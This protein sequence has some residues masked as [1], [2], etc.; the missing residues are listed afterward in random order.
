M[1]RIIPA[2]AALA[3]L[4]VGSGQARAG[5]LPVVNSGFEDPGGYYT[6]LVGWTTSNF[7][8]Y[9]VGGYS[10]P[11]LN[12]QLIPPPGIDIGNN[13]GFT[14][15]PGSAS[16]VIAGYTIQAN[17]TYTLDLL[18]GG[19]LDSSGFGFGGSLIELYDA[20]TSQVLASYELDRGTGVSPLNGVFEWQTTGF[21]TGQAGG[22]INDQL[23]ILLMGLGQSAG[24]DTQ[25]WFDNVSLTA[26]SVPEP[27]TLA[28]SCIMLGT[29]VVGWA[30]KQLK[31]TVAAE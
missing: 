30:C 23:G 11:D 3:L 20:T 16:Q 8:G 21:S 19:R 28:M 6:D 15:G 31:R 5:N 29:F 9:P 27:S 18:V 22:S 24:E 12:G 2:L 1:R 14:Q 26:S 25:T 10:P 4:L 7:S 13:S 17:T